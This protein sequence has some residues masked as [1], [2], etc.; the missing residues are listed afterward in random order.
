MVYAAVFPCY[1]CHMC[2]RG[3]TNW[4]ANRQYPAA[5]NWPYF[6]GTYGDFLYLP[7]R[8]PFFRVPDELPDNLLGPV[9]CAMG[10][11]TTGLERAGMSHGQSVVIMGA[12]GLGIHATAM[13]KERG[14]DRVIVLDR[15]E[16]RLAL[17]EE[18]GADET[19]NIEE[20]NTPETRVRRVRELTRGRGADVVME[21]VGRA[22]LLKEGI[23]M[24]SNG[25]TFV[26]IGDI[27]RG[28]EV[29][30]DP[31]QAASGQEHRRQPDVPSVP[32]AR[33]CW[34]SSSATRN[35]LPFNKL[36]SHTFPLAEV[37][38]AF[39]AAE[40]SQRQTEITRAM[41]VP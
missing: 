1:H 26:E 9:N 31:S 5:G 25:G 41:L 21:L 37:N 40:W 7:P 17:A 29:S 33:N 27:V 4:C 15:L 11:V 19:I 13:A 24:L 23:D 10:T 12:G 14:A 38:E 39:A 32:A 35:R 16:N 2:L 22:D 36:V 8:H 34:T 20:F 18:F 6:T 30:I 3:N 28:Q